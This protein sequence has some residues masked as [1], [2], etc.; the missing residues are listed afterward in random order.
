MSNK[1]KIGEW[2]GSA[3]GQKALEGSAQNTDRVVAE[4]REA[5]RVT[6]DILTR[7]FGPADGGRL[8][9]HQRRSQ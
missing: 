8:W 2:I 1:E 4:L 5:R 3:E 9:P 7:P 6:P